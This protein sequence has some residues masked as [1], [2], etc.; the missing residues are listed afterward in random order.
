MMARVMQKKHK[1]VVNRHMGISR[2]TLIGHRQT[3]DATEATK[4][5]TLRIKCMN[6]GFINNVEI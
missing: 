4:L 3:H 5:R 1:I 6:D 2:A